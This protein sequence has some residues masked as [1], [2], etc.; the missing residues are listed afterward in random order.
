LYGLPTLDVRELGVSCPLPASNIPCHPGKFRSH[1]GHCNNVQHPHWGSSV[2]PFRRDLPADYADGVG[3]PR[4]AIQHVPLASEEQPL[5]SSESRPALTIMQSDSKSDLA[6]APSFQNAKLARLSRSVQSD[7]LFEK[8]R[9]SMCSLW[10]DCEADTDVGR[11]K[12]QATYFEDENNQRLP[13]NKR[14]SGKM[15]PG[16]E[17]DAEIEEIEESLS[18]SDDNS[19]GLPDARTVSLVLHTPLGRKVTDQP[20]QTEDLDSYRVQDSRYVNSSN[21]MPVSAITAVFLQFVFH[22]LAHVAQ[23]VGNRGHRIR[24][25]SV[26]NSKLKHPECWPLILRSSDPLY[27]QQACLEYV[28]SCSTIRPGCTLGAREQI[29]QVTSYL[30]ASVVYGSSEEEA[31]DLRSFQGGRLR[32]QSN[33][34]NVW[35]LPPADGNHDCRANNKSGCFRAGDIRVNEHPGLALMHT[36][37]ARQHNRIAAII[38]QLNPHWNDERLYQESRRIVGA[39]FQHITFNELLPVL[40]GEQFS[41]NLAMVPNPSGFYYGYDM[42]LDSAVSN[43]LA[44]SVFPFIYTMLPTRLQRYT[45][46]ML[47]AGTRRMRDEFFD[48]NVLHDPKEFDQ[49]ALGLLAQR[50]RWPKLWSASAFD[51]I[52]SVDI[53]SNTFGQASNLPID[54]LAIWLQRA[55]DH[56]VPGYSHWR[57]A[58]G[59]RPTVNS[60]DDLKKIMSSQAVKQLRMLYQSIQDIDLFTGGLAEFPLRGALVGPTFACLLGRQF[61]RIRK[62]DR[63]WY[64]NDQPPNRF[65]PQQLEQIRQTTLAGVIC[66][67]L[68]DQ[69]FAQPEAMR[70]SDSYLN[71]FQRCEDLPE[72]RFNEWKEK[73]DEEVSESMISLNQRSNVD[74]VLHPEQLHQAIRN[75]FAELR[76]TRNRLNT[77]QIVSLAS[78]GSAAGQ[79][80]NVLRPKRQAQQQGERGLMLQLVS[81]QLVSSLLNQWAKD[82]EHTNELRGRLLTAVRALPQLRLPDY[83]RKHE[84]NTFSE[85]VVAHACSE[86]RTPCDHSYPFRTHSGWC[87]NLV[88]PSAGTSFHVFKRFLPSVYEDGISSPRNTA[89]SGRTLPSGRAISVAVHG[90]RTNLHTRYTLITMQFG[91]ILDHDLTFT[92]QNFGLNNTILDCSACNS[93]ETV[94]RECWP[95][96]IPAKDSF[97][98]ASN[99]ARVGVSRNDVPRCL[100]FVRSLNGQN[101]LGPREQISQV[102][103]YLDASNI[104]GS[105]ACDAVK[106]RTGS[107]GLLHSTRHPLPN[108]KPLLPLT[109]SNIECRAPSGMCFEAGDLRSSEQPALA[110]MHTVWLREHNRLARQ[111]HTLN[112]HWA[113]ERLFQEARRIVAAEM[114]LI[115]YREFLPRVLGM[116]KANSAGLKLLQSGYSEIYDSSCS[117]T[118]YNEFAAAVFR[119]GH[120]LLRPHFTRLNKNF[121]EAEQPLKL[122]HSFFNSDM[123]FGANGMDNILRGLTNSHIEVLDSAITEEVTNH[124]FEERKKPFSG[125]DLIA[126]NVQRA[127]DHGLPSYNQYREKCN[128]TKAKRFEDLAGEVPQENIERLKSVYE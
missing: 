84:L 122:R 12:K 91:Q 37:W 88:T 58:C 112:P 48:P 43:S 106:L 101:R 77:H 6:V 29:N 123:L 118:V 24:C 92:P 73:M 67:N 25:C 98:S 117:A 4:S 2:M 22:D 128:L 103:A 45:E 13:R 87:N 102:S 61:Q 107:S 46:E 8:N 89:K 96:E 108:H 26:A 124:L 121:K 81:G 72:V 54:I 105:D 109:R 42:K 62:G 11:T 55:R 10:K 1:N 49:L 15:T 38:E 111:L 36:I 79:L 76:N 69:L 68:N 39:Q 56:G 116:Q 125:M 97:F 66:E 104:Y 52:M 119:F 9:F 35:L 110:A 7:N 16:K 113:D 80:A 71:A 100:H 94:H 57:S 60:F 14:Q 70:P 82:E 44:T 85:S 19:F 20:S 120:S 83:V 21:P 63:F 3:M 99:A 30:D 86:Q 75:A 127:R 17:H 95:I 33:Q 47:P 23:S 90:D 18:D 93:K 64:E 115:A 27:S 65:S 126:L 74:S 31:R 50:A 34:A 40:L 41:R 78:S 53:E 5:I 51:T 59:L 28:R 114:Q 32:M